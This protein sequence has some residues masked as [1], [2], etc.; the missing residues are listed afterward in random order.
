MIHPLDLYN[1]DDAIHDDIPY[2]IFDIYNLMWRTVVWSKMCKKGLGHTY[3]LHIPR[4]YGKTYFK[5]KMIQN[6]FD[7]DV[8]IYELHVSTRLGPT[9]FPVDAVFT[10]KTVLIMENWE[11][12]NNAYGAI[13]QVVNNDGTVILFDSIIG[14]ILNVDTDTHFT[15]ARLA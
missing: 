6:G 11:H 10:D 3:Y 13:E 8:T 7:K 4:R 1:I 15:D 5:N 12:N 9:T 2:I 14:P